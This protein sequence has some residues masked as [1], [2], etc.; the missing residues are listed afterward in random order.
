MMYTNGS[1]CAAGVGTA[2]ILISP[3]G[4][5]V[6]HAAQLDFLITNNTS[7]YEALLLDLHRA[8]A[9]GAKRIIIKSD[10]HLVAGNFDKSFTTRDLEMARYFAAVRD[11]A[12]HFL[13]II[14]KT[15]PQRSNEVAD[16]LSKNVQ[17]RAQ[18]PPP[19]K[20][21]GAVP[22]PS[23]I[24]L[25]M[26]VDWWGIIFSYIN[27]K[28]LEDLVEVKRLQYY[29]RHYCIVD[30]LLY[31]GG[32]CTP[33][34]DAYRKVKGKLSSGKFTR[35]PVARTRRPAVSLQGP[36][37]RVCTVPR[38]STT[39]KTSSKVAKDASGWGT[40]RRHR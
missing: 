6:L 40:I 22:G 34:S 15:I 14:V 10:S 17:L 5:S 3:D 16:E 28:D 24:L 30:D 8:K 32:V 39:H 27:G 26:E 1:W 29:A 36:S 13:G 4:Q 31:K 18:P 35:D 11:L 9:L 7:E 19:A 12:R 37:V 2:A 23:P 21:Q 25:I 20:A 33:C 38:C